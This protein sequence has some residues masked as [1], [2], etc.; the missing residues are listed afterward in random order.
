MEKPEPV[1][2]MTPSEALPPEAFWLQ[3]AFRFI[4]AEEFES[5]GVDPADIPLGTFPALKHPSQLPSRY[6]GNAYGIGLFE[7]YD[8]LKPREIRLV[9]SISLERSADLRKHHHQLNTIYKKMGLLVRISARGQPYYLIPAH[10]VSN[11]LSRV[12]AKVEEISKVID[13]HRKKF[14]TEHHRIGV[15]CHRDD[16]VFHELNFR[17]K[18]H[19]FTA[20]DS[21]ERLR[22][23]TGPFDMVILIR[24]PLEAL[25]LEGFS[26]LARELPHREQMLNHAGYILWYVFRLLKR[27]GECFVIAERQPS[28]KETTVEVSFRT[29][30]EAKNFAL[31]THIFK[32]RRRYRLRDGRL[33][34]DSF[35]LHKYLSGLYVSEEDLARLLRG[36]PLES[37]APSQI[38][39]LP[40]LD[41]PIPHRSLLEEQEKTWPRLFAPFF[42]SIFLKSPANE[43][44]KE[45]WRRRF[46][47][48]ENGPDTL[49]IYLGQKRRTPVDLS[50]L[51]QEVFD[52]PL[53]GCAKELVAEYR[54][55]LEYVLR[56][57]DILARL[58]QGSYHE[59]PR[60]YLDRLRQPFE[61]RSRRFSALNDVIKLI[62]KT[63]HLE[64]LRAL[65]NP[66]GLQGPET[67]VLENLEALALHD[68]SRNEL[69]EML[70]IV[71]G[72]TPMGRIL[73]GKMNEKALKPFSDHARKYEIRQA[74][75]LLR[76]IRLMTLAETEAARGAPLR[77]E[78]AAELFDLH[79]SAVRIVSNRDLDWGALVDEK[80]SR[81]GGVR[82]KLVR[83]ILKMMNHYEYLDNWMELR[84]K[85][86]M[87]KEVLAD[88]DPSRVARIQNVVSLIDTIEE[89]ENRY[90]GADP[91][92]G[93]AFYRKFLD[94]EFH[95]TGHLLERM[96][97]RQAFI[98]LWITALVAR[99]GIVNF[100]PI[101]SGIP[102][103]E[104][105]RWVRKVEAEVN[106]I[107][108][109]YLEWENL[110]DLGR[111]VYD[112]GTAFVA[113]TGFQL[114]RNP[115]TQALE[116]ACLDMDRR[117]AEL[118][119]LTRKM[120]A[121]PRVLVVPEDLKTLERL[122]A[123][124]ESF[125]QS[126]LR[127]LQHTPAA[128]RLPLRQRGWFERY[129]A[130]RGDLK[131][132]LLP[133]LFEARNI[134][135]A[136]SLFYDHAPA[137]LRFL[138]PQFMALDKI[139]IGGAQKGPISATRHI[140]RCTRRL[141][142][143]IRH[144]P[145]EFQDSRFLH[146]L[147]QREFGPLATGIVGLS[148][149]QIEEI[150]DI[151]AGLAHNR[152]LMG[153]LAKS[154]V[155]Q[156]I[157]RIPELRDKH[158]AGI[159]TA[160]YGE[161]AATL[162]EKESIAREYG[163]T[164]READT[165]RF[166]VRHHSL[167][168]QIVK[169]ET[170][171]AALEDILKH[172]D[173]DLFDAF[174]VS[175]FIALSAVREGLILE[176]LAA[177]LL[178][179]RTLCQAALSGKTTLE[180]HLAETFAQLGGLHH[181]LEA[182]ERDGLPEGLSPAD[183]LLASQ[184]DDVAPEKRVAAG[185]MIYAM[186]R[187]FRLWGSQYVGFF[188]LASLAVKVPLKFIYKRRHFSDIGYS[189]FEKEIFEASRI[190]NSLRSLPE[191][192]RHFILDELAEDRVRITAFD[193]VRSRLNYENQIKI[194]LIGLLG[195][196]RLRTGEG[197][198]YL[199]YLGLGAQI[200]RRYE[201][202][203]HHLNS[204]SI[205][206][207]WRNRAFLKHLFGAK[208]GL[209]LR[210]TP[211]ANV[212]AVDFRDRIDMDRK[213][214]HM[215]KI[216]RLEPLKAYFHHSL[217]SL[218]RHPFHTEDYERQLEEAFE[219]RLAEITERMLEEIR[220]RMSRARSLSALHR[221]YTDLVERAWEI[222]F[223]AE[224]IHHLADLYEIK[225]EALRRQKAAEIDRRLE[226]VQGE[227]EILK[228]WDRTR[229]YLLRNRKL[230]GKEFEALLARK[231]DQARARKSG[232][233]T[234]A[235]QG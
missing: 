220:G 174:F 21:L 163:L 25:F 211:Q 151:V 107:N 94:M 74:I 212:L 217:R 83:K 15:V 160:D 30:N 206:Q 202:V 229:T 70:C 223:S 180:D 233:S 45:E 231:F 232:P 26:P 150:E 112:H 166:L 101:L 143:L 77:T 169:G 14:L 152:D 155:F 91:L 117:L 210:R 199:T 165:L 60:I 141:Q 191:E 102:P 190:Y 108:L 12:K 109:R 164:P 69:R 71:V 204:V 37:H 123:G 22:H 196:S 20:L 103:D 135:T 230:L 61:N 7:S 67:R 205:E 40:H 216:D 221:L 93:P 187:I 50:E 142:A 81:L 122:F 133:S 162:I 200:E 51:K 66:E 48:P 116:V 10:L 4:K 73:S 197:P 38:N 84:T 46:Q 24:D 193:S 132:L 35:D 114:R 158:A 32:T 121:R 138:L 186:E 110:Q 92:Q 203:N 85:G 175:A 234:P 52:S 213:T 56:T 33:T 179:I 88:Y 130:L 140:I 156:E 178:E 149:S 100:N 8:R 58:R 98:L 29:E 63:G 18:E 192:P 16:L 78:Q 55:S 53:S 226:A 27:D 170:S 227:A 129:R 157:G 41:Y 13:F 181:A 106:A 75:N 105:L 28:R 127:H 168:H 95:G 154:F 49:L 184:W 2:P 219:R 97:G 167:L 125:H 59:L 99:G 207:I 5:F 11:T 134:H 64:K 173:R 225:M 215:A 195:I 182:F 139:P 128:P 183:Y 176:D 87:E 42:D 31:F 131:R 208:T 185:R 177:W 9:Q 118:A 120:A 126:H 1:P 6:G 189:T 80:I 159:N 54:D 79:D 65:L 90:F 228:L 39:E 104:L 36:N 113:G 161:A 153:A 146:R 19:H 218:R 188:D 209:I 96:Q 124:L 136:L 23:Q 62:H 137:L 76:F 43:T 82:H 222:G 198:G 119:A 171:L 86:A 148:D 34:V 57:L 224:Q 115:R 3:D 235:E 89:F 17:F 47:S 214:A 44:L 201:A 194:L 68:F 144:A 72:H 172:R 111:Q 147:A 145:E